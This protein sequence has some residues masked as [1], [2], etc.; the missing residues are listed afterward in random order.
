MKGRRGWLEAQR[1]VGGVVNGTGCYIMERQS[2]GE[3]L[4]AGARGVRVRLAPWRQGAAV[5]EA[6]RAAPG[7]AGVVSVMSRAG[8]RERRGA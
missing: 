7:A 3:G 5:G 8:E 2:V 6:G 4:Q 1:D